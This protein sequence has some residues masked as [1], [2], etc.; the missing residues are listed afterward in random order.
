MVNMV[1]NPITRVAM[2]YRQLIQ[3]PITKEAWQQSVANEFGRLAQGAGGH[4][5]GTNTIRFIPHTDLPADCMPTYPRFVCEVH[6][7]KAENFVQDL[8]WGAT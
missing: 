7:Q 4:I 8:P 3:D 2:E 6:E 1:I 5:K